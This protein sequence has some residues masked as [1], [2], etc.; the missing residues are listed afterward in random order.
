M[1]QLFILSNALI[2]RDDVLSETAQAINLLTICGSGLNVISTGH[3][4]AGY[5]VELVGWMVGSWLASWT[6]GWLDGWLV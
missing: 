6:A 5:R 4:P 2:F 1:I 3:L